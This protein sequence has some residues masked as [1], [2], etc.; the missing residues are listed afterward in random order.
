MVY[1]RYHI[2]TKNA[3]DI[4]PHP[5]RF[6]VNVNRFAL[7]K[8][9]LKELFHYRGN[10]EVVSSRP[11]VY[12]VF[13]GPLGGFAPREKL[14]VGCLRCTTQYPDIVEILH[15]EERR[16][17][18]DSYF[19]PDYVD[20]VVYEAASGRIPVKG[21]GYRGQFGGKGWDGMWTDM[22]E[23]VR[24]TRDGIHG[25]E[26]ISTDIDLGS[27]PASL[28][29][30][31]NGQPSGPLPDTVT[32]AVPFLFDILPSNIMEQEVSCSIL[33]NAAHQTK[34]LAILPPAAIK[35][36][37]LHGPHIIPLVQPG[38]DSVLDMEPPLLELNGWNESFYR[39]LKSALPHTQVI[40]RVPFEDPHLLSYYEAGVRLFH[41]VA[42][43]HGQGQQGRFVLDLIRDV[44]KQFVDCR[45]RSE[46][47]LIGSGGMIAA[48]HIPKA[49][50]CGLDAVA[51]DTALL[52]ALQ[53]K[54]HGECR[55]RTES[56][57]T[58]PEKITAAWGIQRLKNLTGSWRD[59]LLEILGAMGL[60]E[61][62][63][64]RGEIGRA[65]FQNELEDEAFVGID[66]YESKK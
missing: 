8:L 47:S 42:D 64:L 1:H 18:G 39:H 7:A 19:N 9:L 48:E 28:Q 63:R 16:L 10:L 12:G 35:K 26:Y 34:S 31:D 54:F 30:D 61:V 3:P 62:R 22:S 6:K 13:S 50:I 24:P 32:L 46:V 4:V 51:L 17:L 33:A 27:K 23:I 41:L 45:C 49:S 57:F 36:Y 11:C 29:F 58:L 53:A 20:T 66:G 52:T 56:R 37:S 25:R 60:R 5:N 40:V 21:A 55:S 15:N 65:L 2:E 14:C 44:H 59:Q 43:Y 38:D